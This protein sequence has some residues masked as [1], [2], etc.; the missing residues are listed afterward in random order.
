[1]RKY[2]HGHAKSK[3]LLGGGD[4]QRFL[5]DQNMKGDGNNFRVK[6]GFVTEWERG[7]GICEKW[8]SLV[9]NGETFPLHCLLQRSLNVGTRK[10]NGHSGY[11]R[12]AHCF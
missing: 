8:R 6:E 12:R 7:E 2:I 5:W 1:M 9:L 10:R 11:G 3:Q 4:L